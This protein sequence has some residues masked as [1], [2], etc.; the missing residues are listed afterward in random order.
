[1]PK[2]SPIVTLD[3]ILSKLVKQREEHVDALAKIEAVFAKYGITPPATATQTIEAAPSLAIKKGRRRRR[4]RFAQTGEAFVLG[5]L[6]HKSMTGAEVN[7]AWT[8]AGRKARADTTLSLMTKKKLIK[9][10]PVKGGRGS[11]YS[12]G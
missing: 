4:G 12:V 3:K 10:V 11:N 9:R 5:L 8:D 6:E 1:M 7:A 2:F